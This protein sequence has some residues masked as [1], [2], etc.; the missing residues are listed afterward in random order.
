MK[1]ATCLLH[2]LC[3]YIQVSHNSKMSIVVA[4]MVITAVADVIFIKHQS[5]SDSLTG[6]LNLVYI[7]CILCC[8]C[9]SRSSQLVQRN[10]RAVKSDG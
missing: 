6:Y 4:V 5:M 10:I 1:Y 2:K 9:T 3:V 7:T 8:F